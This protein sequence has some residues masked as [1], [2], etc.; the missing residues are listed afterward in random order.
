MYDSSSYKELQMR[1]IYFAT[2]N[3]GKVN[4][5]RREVERLNNLLIFMA[6]FDIP[7]PRGEDVK[8][9]ALAKVRYAKGI[10]TR[11]AV[12]ALDA[13]FYIDCLDGYP[14]ALVNPILKNKKIGV[15]GLL[16]LAEAANDRGC[17][18]KE[19]LAFFDQK[20]AREPLP[21]VAEM[22]GELAREIRGEY[23]QGTHWSEL[24][25]VFVPEGYQKTLAEMTP[26]EYKEWRGERDLSAS[27]KFV[28]WLSQ[29][30][31]GNIA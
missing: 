29:F 19:C 31:L 7:E 8:E 11:A 10:I 2:Q 22:K 16:K 9:I 14:G 24:A 17:A 3:Q 27:S 23:I 12:I 20:I 18:F 4:S 15:L 6:P 25:T 30:D 13:G 21:F 26:A 28:D 5:L 1:T